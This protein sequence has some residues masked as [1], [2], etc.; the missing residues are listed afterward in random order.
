[1]NNKTATT[2]RLTVMIAFLTSAVAISAQPGP[3]GGGGGGPPPGVGPGAPELELLSV[4]S[5][6]P[7]DNL[8]FSPA[9]ATIHVTV[10]HTGG[11][12]G[13]VI[14]VS[15]GSSPTFDPRTMEYLLVLDGTSPQLNYNIF[16]PAGEI[17][18]DLSGPI[19]ADQVIQGNFGNSGNTLNTVNHAFDVIVP[20]EQF[21][22]RG[23]YQDQVEVSLYEGRQ[24]D[25]NRLSLVA[26]ETV[27]VTSETPTIAQIGIAG[28]DD[29]TMDFGLLTEGVQQRVDLL[30]RTNAGF[31]IDAVSENDGVMVNVSQPQS[32]PIPYDLRVGGTLIDLSASSLVEINLLYGT[33]IQFESVPL[34][35]TIG[36]VEDVL[37][38][39]FQDVIIFTI[40]TF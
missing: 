22:R 23:S 40:S 13:Y 30:Y 38:G 25:A 10:G 33:S 28:S 35:V 7:V 27:T 11:P 1:M 32:N 20:A 37:P 34:E 21:V 4:S 9:T 18:R 14:T 6:V 5:T 8:I 39:L 26:R 16:S 24:L 17:A 29:F 3:P 36:T 31:R 12:G 2:R 19:N 15:R